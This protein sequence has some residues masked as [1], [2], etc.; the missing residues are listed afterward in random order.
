MLIGAEASQSE[1][2]NVLS[3]EVTDNEPCAWGNGTAGCFLQVHYGEQHNQ[4][5]FV[6]VNAQF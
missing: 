2:Q 3:A 4:S 6:H 5:D 1:E